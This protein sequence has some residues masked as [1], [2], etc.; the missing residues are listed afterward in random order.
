MLEK[1][2]NKTKAGSNTEMRMS[3]FWDIKSDQNDHTSYLTIK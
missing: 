3:I 1:E 2:D